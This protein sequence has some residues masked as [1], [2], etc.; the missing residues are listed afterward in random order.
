[1]KY[2][3]VCDLDDTLTGDKDGIEVFNKLVL[4]EKG[5]FYLVYSSGRFKDSM[6]FLIMPKV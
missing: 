5:E 4:S 6:I 2:L 3:L 1:M